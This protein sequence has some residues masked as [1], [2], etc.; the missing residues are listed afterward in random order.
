LRGLETLSKW[1]IKSHSKRG[2]LIPLGIKSHALKNPTKYKIWKLDTQKY[3]VPFLKVQP[4]NPSKCDFGCNCGFGNSMKNSKT[5][6][7]WSYRHRTTKFW[8]CDY[9]TPL[10]QDNVAR[11]MKRKFYAKSKRF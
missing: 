2:N 11:H 7:I 8:I 6:P 9:Q 3:Q 10:L 1:G 4:N 5:L